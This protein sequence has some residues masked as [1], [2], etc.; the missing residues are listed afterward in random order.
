M[1]SER[2][3]H[4]SSPRI[5]CDQPD[6]EAAAWK[7]RHRFGDRLIPCDRLADGS[8][9]LVHPQLLFRA[10]GFARLVNLELVCRTPGR[11]GLRTGAR[12]DFCAHCTRETDLRRLCRSRFGLQQ[13]VTGH[14]INSKELQLRLLDSNRTARGP[15]P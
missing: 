4:A 6:L 2:K 13:R 14:G 11:V 7:Q 8:K 3:S 10:G 9:G 12:C 15:M 1:Y 5:Q